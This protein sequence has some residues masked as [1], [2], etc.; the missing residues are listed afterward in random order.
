MIDDDIKWL[1]LIS[2]CL[3]ALMIGCCVAAYRTYTK[4][5]YSEDEDDDED[6]IELQSRNGLLSPTDTQN[7]AITPMTEMSHSDEE[8][9]QFVMTKTNG[10][11]DEVEYTLVL[12]DE[13][14]ELIKD[15]QILRNDEIEVSLECDSDIHI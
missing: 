11:E 3:I 10:I 6:G 2:S 14:D 8:C 4:M 13:T 15:T 7:Y 5:K 12:P 9:V 1:L